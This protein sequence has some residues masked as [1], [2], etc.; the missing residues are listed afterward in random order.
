MTK[1]ITH[2]IRSE[3]GI[4]FVVDVP[5]GDVSGERGI[6]FHPE[7]PLDGRAPVIL[8]LIGHA[9]LQMCCNLRPSNYH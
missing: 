4:N 8:D 7:L 3:S 9:S 2:T 6:G 5:V 1:F